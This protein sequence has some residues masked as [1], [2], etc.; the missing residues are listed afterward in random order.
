MAKLLHL[1]A[2][3]VP[4]MLI[5]LGKGESPERGRAYRRPLTEVVR[6]DY[7]DGPGLVADDPAA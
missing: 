5:V 4:V 7:F 6:M 1:P 2:N 3:Q